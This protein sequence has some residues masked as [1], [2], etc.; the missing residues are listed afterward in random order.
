[1]TF[2]KLVQQTTQNVT[3]F[4]DTHNTEA[5]FAEYKNDLDITCFDRI[6]SLGFR[7]FLVMKSLE[8]TNGKHPLSPEQSITYIRYFFAHHTP[9]PKVDVFVRTAGDLTQGIEYDLKDDKR[10]SVIVNSVSWRVTSKKQHKFLTSSTALEQVAPQATTQSLFELLRPFVN[11]QGNDYTLFVIWLVQS[12][13]SG[14]HSALLVTAERGCG[15]ST[16]SRIIR[17]I[18][19][20]S[21]VDISRFSKKPEELIN[22]LSNLYLVCFDNVRDISQDQSDLLCSAITGATATKRALYTNNDLCVQKLHNTVVM[23]GIAV[24]PQES[25]LAE[26]FLVVT[27]EKIPEEK[28]KREKDLWE[29]FKK[30]LPQILGAI[31]NTLVSAMTYMQSLSLAN[32]P[33]MAD[34]F[35]DMLAIALALGLTEEEFRAI[36]AENVAKMDTLR[37]ETPLVRA[38]R[39][40]MR[41]QNGKR[42][43]EG[44]AEDI[45]SL[46][47]N[48]FSG[49]KDELPQSASRFSQQL[50]KEHDELRKAG[51]RA[52]I[53]DTYADST[54]IKIIR[55]KK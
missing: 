6:D 17:T 48:A 20:P 3:F 35:A 1:M 37:S 53:D 43:L 5:L 8:I 15:K 11:I 16:L 7:A 13:C 51:F 47:Y 54:R 12:F 55:L 34:A 25:D 33:R 9:P 52:N 40:L 46:A 41:K 45:Y 18:L 14:N 50:E 4:R 10:R 44:K 31:F 23:N 29:S 21:E 38:V 26:R 49:T 2:Q 42:S 27:L 22:T 36:Y 32:M 30:T 28:R 39:E 24:A 19:E